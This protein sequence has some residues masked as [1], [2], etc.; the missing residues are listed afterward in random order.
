[1]HPLGVRRDGQAADQS[2]Q[3]GQGHSLRLSDPPAY[4]VAGLSDGRS[5]NWP[6]PVSGSDPWSARRFVDSGE[7]AGAV[8]D[9][10][11]V[12]ITAAVGA[13]VP[14]FPAAQ[15]FQVEAGVVRQEV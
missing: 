5:V 12:F 8:A 6:N 7:K 15:R 2:R 4:R 1:M 14:D 9:A 10:E 13:D 11:Q 3:R